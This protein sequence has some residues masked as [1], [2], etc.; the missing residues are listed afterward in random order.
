MNFLAHLY[1]ADP[2]PASRIGNVLPDIVRVRRDD[3]LP[4]EVRAGVAMHRKVDAFTDTHPIFL[5]SRGRLSKTHGLFAGIIV[6]MLYD[7]LLAA[8]F[9]RWCGQTLE[10][11]TAE[12]Y[13]SI[14][15]RPDLMPEAMHATMHKI[16][17][18]DWLGSYATR[19]GIRYALTR[20]SQRFAQ[21]F[22]RRVELA[23]AVDRLDDV[24][25]DLCDDFEAFFPEVIAMV[26]WSRGPAD[27]GT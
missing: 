15:S 19:E 22:D 12:A 25:C 6:D 3:E 10:A 27:R 1:L 5:R 2:T 17:D 21:R 8:D 26:E 18:E 16:I 4:A 14:L 11:F 24:Q 9:E 20:M 23:S 7:H 13:A